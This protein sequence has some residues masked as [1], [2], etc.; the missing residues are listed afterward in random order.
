[1]LTLTLSTAGLPL[2]GIGYIVAI[3]RVVDM[4]RTMTN[5][6]GQILV[7][8]IVAQEERVPTGRLRRHRRDA[9]SDGEAVSSP[10][11]NCRKRA[12]KK[13]GPSGPPFRLTSGRSSNGRDNDSAL[14]APLS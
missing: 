6:T 3:D 12:N 2:E 8:V 13:G 10:P 11:S 1:M 9:H 7:P 14:T 4:M 5:V